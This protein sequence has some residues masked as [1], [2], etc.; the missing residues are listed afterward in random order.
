METVSTNTYDV[1]FTDVAK[2]KIRQF[3]EN[4]NYS[5][6]F[7]LVD[8]NTEKNCLSYFK[9]LIN[10]NVDATIVIKAGEVYLSLIHI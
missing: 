5:K 10:F 6:V 9:H 2:A 1:H 3:L 8:S 4:S 7:V